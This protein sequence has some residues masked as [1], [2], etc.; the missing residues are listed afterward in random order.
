MAEK[1]GKLLIVVA[2]SGSGKSTMAARLLRD[3]PDLRFSV[4]ATTRA[5]RS[6]ETHGKEYFFLSDQEFDEKIKN[7]DFL[8]WEAFYNGSRYG[9]L[10]SEVDK[11]LQKGYFVLLDLEVK[12]ALNV[13]KR[14]GSQCL[15]VFIE[16]PSLETLR[17]RLLARGTE[18]EESLALRMERAAFEMQYRDK[19]DTSVVNDD[20]ETAYSRIHKLVHDF[21]TNEV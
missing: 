5:P 7:D 13:K 17:Q 14:Y 4:S 16:P 1:A 11:L 2:P 21:F 9:T 18:T 3:F 8:E 19:F 12:G 20:L 15:A 6:G 10:R